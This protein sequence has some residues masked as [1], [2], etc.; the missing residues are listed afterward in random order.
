MRYQPLVVGT[1]TEPASKDTSTTAPPHLA[2]HTTRGFLF[3]QILVLAR[4]HL[5]LALNLNLQSQ[6]KPK[7]KL[8][9]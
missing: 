9:I 8:D 7:Y 1:L 4:L 2:G 5:K 3:L 6:L